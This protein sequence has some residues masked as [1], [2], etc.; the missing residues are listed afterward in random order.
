MRLY[1]AAKDDIIVDTASF[2]ESIEAARFYLDNLGFGGGRLFRADVDPGNVLDV[3]DERHP[4]R[5]IARAIGQSDPGAIGADEYAPRVSYELQDAG[6]DWVRVRESFP[7]DTITWIWVGPSEREPEI[8]EIVMRPNAKSKAIWE[9]GRGPHRITHWGEHPFSWW[10]AQAKRGNHPPIPFIAVKGFDRAGERFHG[11]EFGA[12]ELRQ[13]KA[14][15]KKHVEENE[16]SAEVLGMARIPFEDTYVAEDFGQYRSETPTE[17]YIWGVDKIFTPF[18]RR[19]PFGQDEALREAR[20][21]AERSEIQ[22]QVVTLGDDPSQTGFE[23]VKAYKARSGEVFYTSE[24]GKVGG[25][26]GEYRN[27]PEYRAGRL[28]IDYD[29]TSTRS[30][31]AGAYRGKDIGERSMVTHLVFMKGEDD[32]RTACSQPVENVADPY[33][34]LR[35]HEHDRPTCPRCAAA[36]DKIYGTGSLTPNT[37]G[38]YVWVLRIGSTKPLASEG[39]YG[40]YGTLEGAKPFARISATEGIHDRAISRG[41]DPRSEDFEI[42]RR[43][44]A[45]TGAKLIG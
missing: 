38:Y 45:G 16:G 35:G 14:Y 4:T 9:P 43:Y 27:N 2:A 23:V 29:D 13:A 44:E 15:A 32:L 40:P 21:M 3:V 41:R 22:H 19:G 31:L 1:R 17:F 20:K 18:S 26:L 28:R 12:A 42:V 5:A 24:V 6:Y 36:Y 11:P 33:S 37:S 34:V 39:P 25:R 30:V 7:E 10:R 8:E